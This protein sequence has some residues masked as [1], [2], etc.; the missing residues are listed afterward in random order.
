MLLRLLFQLVVLSVVTLSCIDARGQAYEDFLAA[1]ERGDTN[2]VTELLD[3][4]L[5]PNTADPK[6]NTALMMAARRGHENLVALLLERK[7]SVRARTPH[8]D[9]ALMMASLGGHVGIAK[10]LIEK[11]AQVRESGW[12]PLHYAAFMGHAEMIRFLL[13]SG[14]DK[15]AVAP[16]GYTALMLA[17]RGGHLEAARVLLQEDADFRHKGPRGET[18]LAIARARA[19][20]ALEELLRRAGAVE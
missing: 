3:K 6:G 16:N 10:M 19:D 8:G 15:D 9:T 11:G 5:D 13:A 17:A 1:V 20:N 14:A 7:A 18:A 4:G 12:T 2:V